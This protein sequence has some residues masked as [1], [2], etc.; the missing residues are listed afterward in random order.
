MDG[1]TSSHVQHCAQLLNQIWWCYHTLAIVTSRTIKT[2][3]ALDIVKLMSIF[4]YTHSMPLSA[5]RAITLFASIRF[6]SFRS[7]NPFVKKKFAACECMLS[8]LRKSYE[9][10]VSLSQESYE[11]TRFSCAQCHCWRFFPIRSPQFHFFRSFFY[12]FYISH[13]KFYVFELLNLS[14]CIKPMT[15][16]FLRSMSSLL[17][18]RKIKFR[19]SFVI[20]FGV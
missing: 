12:L 7:T 6:S 14:W 9:H 11:R 1:I 15:S 3:S 10:F 20:S 16:Y 8:Q 4:N 13:N 19:T 2:S 17:I 18:D 5:I